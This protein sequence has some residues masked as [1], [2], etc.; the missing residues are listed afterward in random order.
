M[1]TPTASAVIW[2]TKFLPG[3][4]DNYVSNEVFA[5][6]LTATQVWPYLADSAHWEAYYDNIG[7]ITPPA[8]GSLFMPAA[9]GSHFSFATFGFPPLDM[10]LVEC[11]PPT[12]TTPGRLAW[13]ARNDGDADSAIEVYHAW[14]V[15]D[16]PWSTKDKPLTRILTQET[17]IGK[18]AAQLA[19]AQPNP[20]LNGHQRWLDGLVKYAKSKN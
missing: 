9:V 1:A 8:G 13:H 6:G 20:M 18:P 5:V 10:E 15:E 17:Q 12:A 14:I 7:Q 19:K 2:P 11:V 3:A 16:A 4:T